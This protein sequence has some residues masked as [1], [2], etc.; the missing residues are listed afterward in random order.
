MDNDTYEIEG[1]EFTR[2]QLLEMAKAVA[3]GNGAGKN[4]SVAT[5]NKAI[6]LE[7]ALMEA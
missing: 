7:T 5:W 6:D 1:V 3:D 2:A 4:V